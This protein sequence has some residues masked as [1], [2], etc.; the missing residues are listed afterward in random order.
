[1]QGS[2]LMEK[3]AFKR[4]HE[5]AFKSGLLWREEE[6]SLPNNDKIAQRKQQSLEKKL[7]SCPKIRERYAKSIEDDN[8]QKDLHRSRS[9]VLSVWSFP[10]VLRRK[11]CHGC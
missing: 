1:M 9:S 6:P 10:Q 11:N 8:E 5:D 4:A 3:T 7:E 2:T